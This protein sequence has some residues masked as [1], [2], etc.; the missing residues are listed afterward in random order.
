MSSPIPSL[1]DICDKALR[2]PCSPSLLPRLVSVLEKE[3]APIDE[4]AQ[5]IQIDPVL[6]SSTLRLANSAYFAGAGR[7][8]E[9]LN[10]A[11][12]RLGQREVYRLAALSLTSRWMN[13]K[14]EGYGWEAGDFC[15]LSLVTAVA[16]EYL[17][18]QTK[19]VESRVAYTAGLVMEI[20]K[21]AVAHGCNEHFAAIREYQQTNRANW[22]DAERAILGYSHAEVGAELL[23][24]WKFPASLVAV[25]TYNPPKASDPA[26]F[27]PLLVHVH[28]A[29]YLAVTIG[30][31]VT[32]DG[33]L[34]ELNSTLLMEWGFSPEVLEQAIPHV[35]ERAS[36]LL[37][38]KLSHGSLSF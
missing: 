11:L 24:R 12:L 5:V 10:E 6:A 27:L 4:L 2:L 20:G 28:A 18:E 1:S 8:V 13:Q 25:G 26:D 7:E 15:R 3:D 14:I 31:G 22:L 21:L 9:T 38:D 32:E 23:R 29:K 34:F 19:R 16:A 17:A 35:L 36:K 30:A 37:H 33:F